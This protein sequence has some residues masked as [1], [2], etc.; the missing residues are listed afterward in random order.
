MYHHAKAAQ[1]SGCKSVPKQGL[2]QILMMVPRDS[3]SRQQQIAL[4]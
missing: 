3:Q 2:T 1:R 4:K